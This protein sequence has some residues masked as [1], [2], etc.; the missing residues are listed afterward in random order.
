[1]KHL[2]VILLVLGGATSITLLRPNVL[3]LE[4]P[5]HLRPGDQIFKFNSSQEKEK[6]YRY[7]TQDESFFLANGQTLTANRVSQFSFN[8]GVVFIV[9]G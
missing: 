6:G 8:Y 9:L 3:R 1:M 4:V 7:L 2:V 5:S